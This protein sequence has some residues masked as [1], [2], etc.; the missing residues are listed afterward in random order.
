M[1]PSSSSRLLALSAEELNAHVEE[2]IGGPIIA[3]ELVSES[4][5][6]LRYT[7]R[8][9]SGSGTDYA[10]KW[11]RDLSRQT[12]GGHN[13][14]ETEWSALRLLY[15]QGAPVPRPIAARPELGLLVTRWVEGETLDDRAQEEPDSAR[16]ALPEIVRA[17][18]M[19][20]RALEVHRGELGPYVYAMD[21]DAY[22]GEDFRRVLVEAWRGYRLLAERRSVPPE[23]LESLRDLWRAVVEAVFQGTPRF[24][25]LDYTAR[26]LLLTDSEPIVLDFSTLGW[27]WSER[28]L[29]QYTTALGA[30]RSD[31]NFVSLLNPEGLESCREAW[32][33]HPE[34]LEAHHFVFLCLIAERLL[35]HG[36]EPPSEEEGAL[37]PAFWANRAARFHR[38]LKLLAQ[39]T[40]WDFEPTRLLRERL[41]EW[42]GDV[43]DG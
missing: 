20:D 16:A 15:D 40:A 42:Y 17:L 9:R 10:L 28:R 7:W 6:G 29:V 2:L 18:A 37:H 14:T 34:V 35:R 41:R 25:S 26:N 36:I 38:V 21:Y 3:A 23:A 30:R 43:A 33:F 39:G 5:G 32:F 1:N 13:S 4:L 19:V 22:L 12:Q 31:G 8:I 24:G 27:D 11:T